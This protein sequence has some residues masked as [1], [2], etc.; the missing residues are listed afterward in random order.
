MLS[1]S[2][3]ATLSFPIKSS[4]SI[5]AS[6]NPTGFSCTLYSNFIPNLEPSPNKFL[7]AGK[8][9]GVEI[10]KTSLIPDIIN[11]DNG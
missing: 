7:N 8:C 1:P 9:T 4:P 3:N 2:I 6:A 5:K 10:I 11:V